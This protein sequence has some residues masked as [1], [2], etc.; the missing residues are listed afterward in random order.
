MLCSVN[1]SEIHPPAF[2]IQKFLL[3]FLSYLV[4]QNFWLIYKL[5]Y[6]LL[7][8]FLV[9]SLKT[10]CWVFEKVS[11][12]LLIAIFA[13]FSICYLSGENPTEHY[14]QHILPFYE[15][16]WFYLVT[17]PKTFFTCFIQKIF[18][19]KFLYII[20]FLT[21]V[22]SC[23]LDRDDRQKFNL[24]FYWL[25]PSGIVFYIIKALYKSYRFYQA[26]FFSKPKQTHESEEAFAA[27]I[28]RDWDFPFYKLCSRF[29]ENDYLTY[30]SC[31]TWSHV[32]ET[33]TFIYPSYD[34][35]PHYYNSFNSPSDPFWT[36]FWTKRY[37]SGFHAILKN[38][39]VIYSTRELPTP[40]EIIC[41]ISYN[42]LSLLVI[43]VLIWKFSYFMLK[44]DLADNIERFSD[45]YLRK[46]ERTR[47][48]LFIVWWAYIFLFILYLYTFYDGFHWVKFEDIR[49][50]LSTKIFPYQLQGS[51]EE[52]LIHNK[53]N[54]IN[55][56][57][58]DLAEIW[59]KNPRFRAGYSNHLRKIWNTL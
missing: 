23:S 50:V 25:I 14:I 8:R 40:I 9:F 38:N 29:E 58:K 55:K 51:Y 42:I 17:Y 43:S 10:L 39:E 52:I 24:F 5:L 18:G 49:G 3:K 15:K 59:E 20:L 33:G 11:I 36:S 13:A 56:I 57:D 54:L 21:I 32:D 6:I 1:P 7:L 48:W 16:L 26:F 37:F 44:N 41:N 27:L 22:I 28:Y 2:F 45:E 47:I 34:I 53:K 4:F 12:I 30:K 35:P 31:V 46:D 19:I